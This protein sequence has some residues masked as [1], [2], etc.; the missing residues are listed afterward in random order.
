MPT[1][2]TKARVALPPA[3]WELLRLLTAKVRVASGPQ[4]QRADPR[5]TRQVISELV[6]GRLVSEVRLSLAT[7]PPRRTPFA[8]VAAG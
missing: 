4:L 5:W 1:V 8:L 6:R 3:S 2:K 7:P